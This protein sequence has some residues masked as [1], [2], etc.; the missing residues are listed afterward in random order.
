MIEAFAA[1]WDVQIEMCTQLLVKQRRVFAR[2]MAGSLRGSS[3]APQMVISV[4]QAG[5]T[6]LPKSW[7]NIAEDL[8]SPLKVANT[9]A[10]SAAPRPVLAEIGDLWQQVQSQAFANENRGACRSNQ[11]LMLCMLCIVCMC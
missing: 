4:A 11:S 6:P 5:G 9:A 3:A 1:D 10:G 2:F 7:R 8:V